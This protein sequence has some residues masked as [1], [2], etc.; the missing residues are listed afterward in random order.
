MMLA[1]D[2]H[3]VDHDPITHRARSLHRAVRRMLEVND[4]DDVMMKKIVVRYMTTSC[5]TAP[6]P[7]N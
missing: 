1:R 6:R 5:L 7:P 2:E 3:S 4:N